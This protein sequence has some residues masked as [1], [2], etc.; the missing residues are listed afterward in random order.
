MTLL[1]SR[2]L[3]VL[4]IIAFSAQAVF[5]ADTYDAGP[6]LETE[7]G[8]K[9]I[10][11]NSSIPYFPGISL[12]VTGGQKYRPAFGP[13]PWRMK[14]KPNSVKILF[15]GQD[16]THIAEAA[17]RPATAGFGGRAQD[18]AKYFGVGSSAAFINT[19]AFTIKGQYGAFEHP[20]VQTN[21]TGEF[22]KV[23]YG[24]F[25]DNHLWLMTQD[26]SSPIAQWRN[27][28]I[29]WIIANNKDSL[30]MIVLFGGA[31]R[32]AA[33][34]YVI[35]H[36]GKVG[37]RTSEEALKT[38]RVPETKLT[39]SGG[40]NET[41]Y[42]LDSK[43]G[44]L[45]A[46]ILGKDKIKYTVPMGQ[47]SS[48]EVEAAQAELSKNISKW[49]EELVIAK[50]GINGSGVINPAQLGGY[51][52]ARKMEINGKKTISLK[53]LKVSNKNLKLDFTIKNDLLVVQLPHPSSLS[54]MKPAEAAQKVGAA[55][56]AFKPYVENGWKIDADDGF[57]NT[58]AKGEEYKYRR[59]D[60][61]PETYDFGAPASRM[62][63]VSSASRYKGEDRRTNAIVF[64]TRD[65]A[66]FDEEKVLAMTLAQPSSFPAKQEM[67]TTRP[68]S[69][70][71]RYTFDPGPGDEYA[72]LMKENIPT[73]LIEAHSVNRDFA[74]YRG[75]FVKPKA[76]IV[77]DPDGYDDLIT[78][79]A[80]TGTRGQ[81]LHGL[82][83]DLGYG[84]QYLVFKTAPFSMDSPEDW[85]SIFDQTKNYRSVVLKRILQ[86]SK[87]EVI[88]ADGYYAQIE[89]KRIFKGSSVKVINIAR[90]GEANN[91]GIIEAAKALGQNASGKMVDIPR[92]HLSYYAR[93][94]EGTSG[95]RVLTATDKEFKGKA[96]IEVA[97]YWATSQK[98][99][100]SK[101][102]LSGIK[103][104]NQK[105]KDA[106]LRFG[107]ETIPDFIKRTF[108]W[109]KSV[110]NL[111]YA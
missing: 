48:P 24:S 37:T 7:M 53:G 92:S 35:S 47:A 54:T 96:F 20:I 41:P 14:Q 30:K 27:D 72:R 23:T 107:K 100:M 90:D 79:R 42:V 17:G 63:N 4:Q 31:A 15:I 65:K 29:D 83:E 61:G 73:E 95:D 64:G 10:D 71:T 86:D 13:M 26:L 106:I 60:M 98:F 58:F 94:W 97:P 82:M 109:L 75:T 89:V 50:G 3:V 9:L 43:G 70:K 52:I 78:A 56:V 91:S 32:D 105:I 51:D 18:L 25:V 111:S 2:F 88:F 84:D 101:E 11:L 6:D 12:E 74:H 21:E 103:A 36:G 80:L 22:Q 68:I 8:K 76:L 1:L 46:K 39:N 5:A 69:P 33:A 93:I 55:L 102:D 49:G 40:N 62:V 57:E 108:A 34:S 104:L 28:L 44:D 59:G 85:K 81:Y 66:D 99:E 38:I 19:Y 77:A 87:P 45:Y 16:G 110:F 67:W